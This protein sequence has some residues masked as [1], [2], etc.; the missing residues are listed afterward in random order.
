MICAEIISP[1]AMLLELYQDHKTE[2]NVA[3]LKK[4]VSD[5]GVAYSADGGEAVSDMYDELGI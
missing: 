1:M 3:L 4:Y 2:E 5:S